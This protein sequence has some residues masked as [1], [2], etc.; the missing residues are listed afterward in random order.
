MSGVYRNSGRKKG[1][2]NKLTVLREQCTDDVLNRIHTGLTP[3]QVMLEAM[4]ESYNRAQAQPL[5]S[6]ERFEHMR[7]AC[8]FAK[9]AAP[10]VHAKKQ[11]EQE[12]M[13]HEQVIVQVSQED[14][15][16]VV[17]DIQQHYQ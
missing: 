1:G 5:G 9:E 12:L 7:V 11:P 3:L 8:A 10:Y 6:D 14:F 16:Q 15:A 4:N 17:H 13:Q 2:K